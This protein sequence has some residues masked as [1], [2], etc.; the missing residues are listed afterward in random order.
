MSLVLAI[1][2]GF[3]L[4]QLEKNNS[5]PIVGY[6]SSPMASYQSGGIIVCRNRLSINSPNKQKLLEPQSHGI[7]TQTLDQRL[8]TPSPPP[9][10]HAENIYS[11]YFPAVETG[12]PPPKNVI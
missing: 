8:L 3:K 2:D 5:F 10:K 4:C 1:S 9:K 12:L 11:S 6:Q 7:E